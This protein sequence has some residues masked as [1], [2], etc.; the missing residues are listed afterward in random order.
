MLK[1]ICENVPQAVEP[2]KKGEGSNT[3]LI[4]RIKLIKTLRRERA[5]ILDYLKITQGYSFSYGFSFLLVISI[6]VF[7]LWYYFQLS[8][9]IVNSIFISLFSTCSVL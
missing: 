4:I 7:E 5:K 8:F 9:C 1:L 2:N 3:L 6:L